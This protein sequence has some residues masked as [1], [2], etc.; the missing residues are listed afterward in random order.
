MHTSAETPRTT[1]FSLPEPVVII[2]IQP[3]PVPPEEI[4]LRAAADLTADGA[5]GMDDMLMLL[6]HWGN[7]PVWSELTCEGDLNGDNVVDIQ[8][9]LTIIKYWGKGLNEQPK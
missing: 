8:D 1:G 9:L 6:S 5:I 7:C 3:L 2:D 4:D